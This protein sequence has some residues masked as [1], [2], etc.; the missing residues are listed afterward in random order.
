MLWCSRRLSSSSTKQIVNFPIVCRQP[1]LL[2]YAWQ[3]ML[4][5]EHQTVAAHHGT[6]HICSQISWPASQP[7]A[8][9]L[10][11]ADSYL[12]GPGGP[13]GLS[14]TSTLSSCRIYSSKERRKRDGLH[15]LVLGPAPLLT[16]NQCLRH[17]SQLLTCSRAC[18]RAERRARAVSAQ[19]SQLTTPACPRLRTCNRMFQ[20]VQGLGK[21]GNYDW[22]GHRAPSLG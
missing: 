4:R 11:W 3:T 14:L 20:G 6:S 12:P 8:L 17:E 19:D 15:G 9:H 7:D 2:S 22:S 5:L 10:L 21:A 13:H 16:Y 18:S 1:E